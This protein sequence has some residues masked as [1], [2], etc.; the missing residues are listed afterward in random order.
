M[1]V[2]FQEASAMSC[3]LICIPKEARLEH[4]ACVSVKIP[5]VLEYIACVRMASRG[6]RAEAE[7]MLPGWLRIP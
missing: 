4:P 1:Y 2:I 5:G 3:V 7:G 6:E